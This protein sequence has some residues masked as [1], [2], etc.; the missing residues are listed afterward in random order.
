MTFI[1][2]EQLVHQAAALADDKKAVRPMILDLRDVSIVTDYFL[3]VGAQSR[4]QAYAIADHVE[5]ELALCGNKLYSRENDPDGR[6][7]LLDYGHVVVHVFKED[8]RD[9]YS[10]E[11]LWGEARLIEL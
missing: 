8:V 11:R 1:S 7:I 6:W 3:I 5:K 9:F 10:L 4:T 2:S